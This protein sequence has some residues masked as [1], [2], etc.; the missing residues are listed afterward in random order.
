MWTPCSGRSS[1][2]GIM[3]EGISDVWKTAEIR[4]PVYA[5]AIRVY[6]A[7]RP[8]AGGGQPVHPVR[9]G[10]HQRHRGDRGG[11]CHV[12]LCVHH[13]CHVCHRRHLYGAALLQGPAGG[14]GLSDAHPAGAA[15]G[16]DRL[17]AGVR[18]GAD[19]HQHRNRYCVHPGDRL[20]GG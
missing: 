8:G 1:G 4:F 12:R 20:T 3:R 17:Q 18:G 6:L 11:N 14:R 19:S 9:P 13:D 16:A 2:R 5:E 7:R 15:L 10:Q